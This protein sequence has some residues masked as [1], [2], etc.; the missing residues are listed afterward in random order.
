M[1]LK[2]RIEKTLNM[3]TGE[4]IATINHRLLNSNSEIDLTREL[5]LLEFGIR[6]DSKRDSNYQL[7]FQRRLTNK[8]VSISWS[9]R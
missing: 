8:H 4:V 1:M 6:F 3:D 2:T 7:E 9:A 5:R